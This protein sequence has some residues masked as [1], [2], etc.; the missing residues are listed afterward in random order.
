MNVL[1]EK[2]PEMFDRVTMYYLIVQGMFYSSEL[3]NYLGS[4]FTS[5]FVVSV[6]IFFASTFL[7]MRAFL[8][9][10]LVVELYKTL[11]AAIQWLRSL[12]L[13][14]YLTFFAVLF[15]WPIILILYVFTTI[16]DLIFKSNQFASN[17]LCIL[18]GEEDFI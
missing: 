2:Y 4:V 14:D 15:F 7:S 11:V 13:Q 8:N 5:N 6:Y 3:Y 17:L 18:L 12:Q 9:S 1:V 16:G 10:T